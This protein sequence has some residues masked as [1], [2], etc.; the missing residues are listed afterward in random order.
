MKTVLARSEPH[1]NRDGFRSTCRGTIA[2]TSPSATQYCKIAGECSC[3]KDSD[4]LN[5]DAEFK[6]RSQFAVLQYST[7]SAKC[8]KCYRFPARAVMD[9]CHGKSRVGSQA[10]AKAKAWQPDLSK[11]LSRRWPGDKQWKTLPQKSLAVRYLSNSS[12]TP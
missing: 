2:T 9:W 4:G 1:F 5:S 6:V 8:F 7:C 11:T 12:S 3:D 10:K